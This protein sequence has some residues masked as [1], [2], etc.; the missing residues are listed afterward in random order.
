MQPDESV[1]THGHV[2]REQCGLAVPWLLVAFGKDTLCT[3]ILLTHVY[4]CCP[5]L[6][7]NYTTKS[8]HQSKD[9]ESNH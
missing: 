8:K 1:G 9:G 4:L 6:T 3:Y 7:G 5:R 2:V